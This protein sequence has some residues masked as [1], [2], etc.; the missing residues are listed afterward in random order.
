MSI[1]IASGELSAVRFIVQPFSAEEMHH[2]G[3][4][5]KFV[6]L[7]STVFGSRHA[8]CVSDF[9]RNVYRRGI[10]TSGN[11]VAWTGAEVDI[12]GGLALKLYVNPYSFIGLSFGDFVRDFLAISIGSICQMSNLVTLLKKLDAFVPTIAAMNIGAKGTELKLYFVCK[13]LDR[14]SLWKMRDVGLDQDICSRLDRLLLGGSLA[15]Q[16][17][18]FGISL[19]ESSRRLK[20]N[21]L[22][23]SELDDLSARASLDSLFGNDATRKC[24]ESTIFSIS[25]RVGSKARINFLGL[26]SKKTD[27]YFNC[28]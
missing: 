26:S 22:L 7:L 25:R 27:V 24:L 28:A 10:R 6:D 20:V 18:H 9:L 8:H 16:E 5:I 3:W 1:S 14:R 13:K 11:F 23:N 17:V 4:S 15:H 19:S 21:L 2:L 12:T